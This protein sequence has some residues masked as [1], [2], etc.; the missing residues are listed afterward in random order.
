MGSE[1][2]ENLAFRDT[3]AFIAKKGGNNLLIILG[4]WDIEKEWCGMIVYTNVNYKH[5]R[6][7]L[8]PSIMDTYPHPIVSLNRSLPKKK[9][10]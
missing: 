7:A 5:L 9:D 10:I 2:V 6:V 1:K 8:K 3:W 4:M